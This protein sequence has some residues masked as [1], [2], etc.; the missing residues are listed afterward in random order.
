M[1]ASFTFIGSTLQ[2]LSKMGLMAF[3]V[4]ALEKLLLNISLMQKDD[5][6]KSRK[7]SRATFPLF[8]TLFKKK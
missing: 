5:I 7:V 6:S 2:D 3:M 8:L 4:F 1:V